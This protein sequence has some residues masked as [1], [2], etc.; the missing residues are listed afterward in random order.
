MKYLATQL[1][2]P[3]AL[4]DAVIASA[5]ANRRSINAEILTLLEASLPQVE[6]QP[7]ERAA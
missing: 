7:Q 3:P 5:A 6:A 2:W 4:R 1:R